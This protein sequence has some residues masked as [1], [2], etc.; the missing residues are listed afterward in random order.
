MNETGVAEA[1]PA[2]PEVRPSV[3]STEARDKEEEEEIPGN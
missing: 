1:K 2:E 3:R